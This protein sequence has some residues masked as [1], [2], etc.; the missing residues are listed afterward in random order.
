MNP[1]VHFEMP[2]QDKNRMADFY[3]KTF[4]WKTQMLGPDMGDYILVTTAETDE[5]MM[6]KNPG[7]INGGF[8]IKSEELPVQHTSVVIQVE[9]IDDSIQ[10]V[11]DGGGKVLGKPQD[12]PGVGRFVYFE[13]TENNI[14]GMLQPFS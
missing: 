2:A 8:Y 1:V 6:V 9:N 3:S 11:T 10:K 4:G 5:N 14:A 13:D 7:Q 12:I